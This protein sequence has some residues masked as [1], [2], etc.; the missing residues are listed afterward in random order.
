[1]P[2]L[3]DSIKFT[4][5]VWRMIPNPYV[6]FALGALAGAAAAWQAA[7]AWD[8]RKVDTMRDQRDFAEQQKQAMEAELARRG[9]Q[10]APAPGTPPASLQV[11]PRK[12]FSDEKVPLDG[13]D[14]V[15]CAFKNVTFVYNGTA[16]FAITAPYTTE[17][18]LALTTESDRVRPLLWL[19][20]EFKGHIPP[21]AL[22][23]PSGR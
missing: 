10:P 14:Y 5:E 20:E 7:K 21:L 17:G 2:S 6:F 18:R 4:M 19:L 23:V 9:S 15:G 16:P 22:L 3:S 12:K 11:I 1:M 13:F 8:R